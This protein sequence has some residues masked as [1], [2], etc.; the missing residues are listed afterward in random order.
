MA[1]APTFYPP[2]PSIPAVRKGGT[3]LPYSRAGAA[4]CSL[5][6]ISQGHFDAGK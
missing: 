6:P 4:H 5:R 3:G 1:G 2:A